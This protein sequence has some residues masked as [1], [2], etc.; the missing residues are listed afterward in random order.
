MVPTGRRVAYRI[1]ADCACR[2]DGLYDEWLARDQSTVLRQL[3]FDP[4]DWARDLIEREGGA[5]ACAK[6]LT[7]A[8]DVPGA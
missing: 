7:P 3:A 2:D 8:N 4:I 1:I 6:P 5:A